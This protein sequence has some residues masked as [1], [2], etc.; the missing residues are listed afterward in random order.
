MILI[1][2]SF[3]VILNI[4]YTHWQT[5]LSQRT[6]SHPGRHWQVWGWSPQIPK[7]HPDRTSQSP[8]LGPDQPSM[9]LKIV[10]FKISLKYKITQKII[11]FFKVHFKTKEFEK[12]S[13]SETLMEKMEKNVWNTLETRIYCHTLNFSK[14]F[15][16][17]T[18]M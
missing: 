10:C 2:T 14:L 4:I 3:Y 18:K 12:K 5:G 6:P 9:Q 17:E 8:H 1:L 15:Q 7:R 16:L 13:C 11:W